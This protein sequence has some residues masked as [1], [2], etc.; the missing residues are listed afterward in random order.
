ML[1]ADGIKKDA[2]TEEENPGETS[3][4]T[5]RSGNFQEK[6]PAADAKVRLT[7]MLKRRAERSRIG[8]VN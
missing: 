8:Q 4:N 2:G 5:P 3:K 1:E 6:G 7:R